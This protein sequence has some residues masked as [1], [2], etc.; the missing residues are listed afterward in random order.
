MDAAPQIGPYA[1]LGEL[2]RGGMGVVYRARRGD[3]ER[4]FALKV[5]LAGTGATAEMVQRFRR[6]AQAAAAL[7]GEPGIVGVHDI[8]RADD[9]SVY[10]AM[11]LVEGHSLEDVLAE[12]ELTQEETVR[13]CA[14]AA[15]AVGRAHARGILHRDLK[16]ANIMVT[17]DGR[18]LV[19][20][21]GLAKSRGSPNRAR[22]SGPP[23]T[24]HP[25]RPRAST[26]RRPPTSTRSVPRSTK[27]SR[28][29]RPSPATPSTPS[30][31]RC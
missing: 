27:R 31:R 25:N 13:L 20:D 15:H 1:I 4:E 5:I 28:A 14:A 7:A 8:G 2:G 11:D 9:G 22:C 6:E 24:W 26:A 3:L 17:P 18:A 29:G 16:P 10:F 19:T 21:F 23:P 30:W 12:G